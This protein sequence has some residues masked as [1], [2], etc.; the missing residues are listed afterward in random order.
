M[1]LALL[2]IQ[3]AITSERK[4]E[5]KAARGNNPN[6]VN[7]LSTHTQFFFANARLWTEVRHALCVT[8]LA[9]SYTI[10]LVPYVIRT[11]VDQIK[12]GPDGGYDYAYYYNLTQDYLVA[13]S[14]SSSDTGSPTPSTVADGSASNSSSAEGPR[15]VTPSKW[16]VPGVS[17]L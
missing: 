16:E 13:S 2:L 12:K 7:R 8:A 17:E 1:L 14:S 11:K 4:R 15:S 5:R 3:R 6:G 9:V 10:C